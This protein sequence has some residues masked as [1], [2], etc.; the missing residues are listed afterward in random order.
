MLKYFL[1][2]RPL[3]YTNTKDRFSQ[4]RVNS[5]ENRKLFLLQNCQ[6]LE[7]RRCYEEEQFKTFPRLIFFAAKVCLYCTHTSKVWSLNQTQKN[8]NFVTEKKRQRKLKTKR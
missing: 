5:L 3:K 1:R 2:D 7:R 6:V 8:I 4:Q